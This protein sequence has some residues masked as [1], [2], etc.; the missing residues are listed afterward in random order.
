MSSSRDRCECKVGRVIEES[1]LE[2]VD[3]ELVARRSGE[4]GASLRDLADYFNQE[5]VRS[6]LERAGETPL[7][8][9]VENTYRLL[10]GDDVSNGMRIRVRKRLEGEDIDVEGIEEGFV[11][12]PTMGK[13]LEQCLDVERTRGPGDRIGTARER[14]FKMQNRAEAVTGN[15]LSGL[16]SAD[17]LA[18]GDLAVNVD[19][20]VMCEECGVYV[21]VAEFIERGGCDCDRE[22]IE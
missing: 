3:E 10:T 13:H 12:H 16:A 22:G 20:Q 7:D 11:S 8:G 5:V 19:I 18:V 14:I 9:E 21:G 6:A 15:T 1:G 2:D 17:A 4:S